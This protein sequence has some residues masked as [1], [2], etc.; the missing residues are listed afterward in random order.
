M[1]NKRAR[2]TQDSVH[3]YS[4]AGRHLLSEAEWAW[5]AKKASIVAGLTGNILT[6]HCNY[7]KKDELGQPQNNTFKADKPKRN[8]Y[9]KTET[10][11]ST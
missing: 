6:A 9:N 5:N 4:V 10:E 3:L 11:A 2:R 7:S 8:S 1:A